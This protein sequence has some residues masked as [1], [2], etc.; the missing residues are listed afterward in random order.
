MAN[1]PYCDYSFLPKI[2]YNITSNLMDNEDAEIIWKL[3]KYQ[4]KDDWN[5]TDLTKAEKR[6][7]IYN[8]DGNSASYAL[9]FDSGMDETISGEKAYLR[10]YPY[11]VNPENPYTGIIDIAFEILCHNSINT[12]SNYTTRVDSIMAALLK[13]LNG[14]NV[15]G[16]GAMYFDAK[17]SRGNK[18]QNFNQVPFKAKILIMST[19]VGTGAG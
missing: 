7:L 2:A 11:Y 19:N 8:G 9:F 12:L 15:G 16:L 6:A 18:L 1:K 4:T 14:A 10:I 17:R 13:C 3:L 5:A